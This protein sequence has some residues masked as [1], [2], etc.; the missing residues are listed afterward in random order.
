MA[1]RRSKV[2]L[3]EWFVSILITFISAV[4]IWTNESIDLLLKFGFNFSPGISTLIFLFIT[5][6]GLSWL[7]LNL[8][9]YKK[10]I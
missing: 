6:C 8:F 7:M 10:I 2:K 3:W 1:K 4:I 9:R 5:A